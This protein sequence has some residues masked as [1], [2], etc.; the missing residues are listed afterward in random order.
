M[1]VL[2]VLVTHISVILEKAW[3]DM[4]LRHIISE[5]N[6]QESYTDANGFLR[7]ADVS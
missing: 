1:F 5:R 7:A 3:V 4:G 2:L 6:E